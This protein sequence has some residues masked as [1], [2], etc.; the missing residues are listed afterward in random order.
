MLLSFF[1][2]EIKQS[3]WK[4][5]WEAMLLPWKPTSFTWAS[6]RTH[7]H[8]HSVPVR[9]NLRGLEITRGKPGLDF[10]YG[11]GLDRVIF[12]QE[13]QAYDYNHH[14][15][16]TT[17]H[18]FLEA[19]GKVD[20]REGLRINLTEFV[21]CITLQVLCKHRSSLSSVKFILQNSLNNPSNL[22]LLQISLTNPF[23]IV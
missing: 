11:K 22:D 19:F 12:S 4:H 5:H 21:R 3:L 8:I 10:K 6:A 7:T 16:S 18:W 20:S 9:V 23:V 17:K 13:I 1:N 15:A 2:C 14:H